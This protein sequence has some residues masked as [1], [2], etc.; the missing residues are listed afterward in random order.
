MVDTTAAVV[1]ALSK[2]SNVAAIDTDAGA[3]AGTSGLIDGAPSAMKSAT[4]RDSVRVRGFMVVST[5]AQAGPS[6]AVFAY[7]S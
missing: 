7:Q 3:L 4:A 2:P 5:L 1:E 6:A